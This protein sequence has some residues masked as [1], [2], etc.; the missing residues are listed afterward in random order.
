MQIVAYKNVEVAGVKCKGR[1]ECVKDL[2][3][4]CNASMISRNDHLEYILVH[5]LCYIYLHTY[6]G[7]TSNSS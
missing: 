6:M 2:L 5:V 7:Q 3:H 1:G 4:M